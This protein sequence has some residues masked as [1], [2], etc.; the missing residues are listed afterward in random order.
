MNMG[1]VVAKFL[2]VVIL[3]SLTLPISSLYPPSKMDLQYKYSGVTLP[4]N[5]VPINKNE[6]IKSET[7][8]WM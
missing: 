6:L 3:L 4:Y 7:D 8:N 5:I 1:V 2:N